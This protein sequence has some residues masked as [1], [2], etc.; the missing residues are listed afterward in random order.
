MLKGVDLKGVGDLNSNFLHGG[1]V[2][3]FW[4]DPTFK[5]PRLN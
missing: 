5:T 2:D 4:N 1:G 3:V